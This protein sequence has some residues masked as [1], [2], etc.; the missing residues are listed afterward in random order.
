[1]LV[2]LRKVD[3]KHKLEPNYE[4]PYRVIGIEKPNLLLKKL[5]PD[6]TEFEAHMDRCKPYFQ[7]EV[8]ERNEPGNEIKTR[9]LGDPN[10]EESDDESEDEKTAIAFLRTSDT[11]EESTND[12]FDEPLFLME[13]QIDGNTILAYI[14]F[15]EN[16][17]PS[18]IPRNR[19]QAHL[20]IYS[21]GQKPYITAWLFEEELQIF[22]EEGTDR[23]Y[24]GSEMKRL[25]RQNGKITA[26]NDMAMF[27][28][29]FDER[30][31]TWDEMI[32]PIVESRDQ[33]SPTQPPI[34][35]S[36]SSDES[37]E[38]ASE[39]G[40]QLKQQQRPVRPQD[41]RLHEFSMKE[42]RVLSTTDEKAKESI[43]EKEIQELKQKLLLLEA[44]KASD[45]RKA[46]K[47]QREA[48][49]RAK[50]ESEEKAQKEAEAKAKSN[51]R[52]PSEISLC[53]DELEWEEAEKKAMEEGRE[54][55]RKIVREAEEK[56][57]KEAE[58]KAQREAEER[59]K[60]E[61]EERAKLESEEKA[62]KEAEAKAKRNL[63]APSEIS[64]CSR[65]GPTPIPCWNR[66]KKRPRFVSPIRNISP[67]RTRQSTVGTQ[68]TNAWPSCT[69]DVVEQMQLMKTKLDELIAALK[70]KEEEKNTGNNEQI[71]E[72]EEQQKENGK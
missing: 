1:M 36:I 50:R 46:A 60:R 11:D 45:V 31:Q 62:Q 65:R 43:R 47:A 33:S 17:E 69:G 70:K 41:G 19:V 23:P 30:G 29:S 64:L 27:W 20:E 38:E 42:V 8:E 52:A 54:E 28:N 6:G 55:I 32:M 16:Y 18:I 48:E 22:V 7:R 5:N 63:R 57:K 51:L 2:L 14:D 3:K 44:E 21:G 66:Y 25:L 39:A 56:A 68:T 15:S 59:A 37:A 34:L 12:A 24:I 58:A 35:V 71:G 53:E 49:E 13:I 67:V 40:N 9:A 61:A 26:E 72:K 10:L 4:G